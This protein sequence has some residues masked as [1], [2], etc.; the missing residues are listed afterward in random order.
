MANPDTRVFIAFD[1]TASGGSFFA[2][3]DPVRGVL[4]S[5]YVLGGDV[6]VDVTNYVASVSIN[7]GKSRELDRFTAGNASV[8][9]HNDDRT[10][11]PFYSDSPFFSQI[12]PRKQVVIE[13]NGIRQ[14]TGYIDD[15]DLTYELGGKSFASISCIDGFMQLSATQL[16]EFTN[17]SQLSGSRIEAIINRPEVAWPAG[18]RDIDAG[19]ETLQADT[20]AENTNV[21]QYLQLIESTEPGALFMSKSGALT[22]RDRI[23]IPPLV[24]TLIF[25]DDGRAESVG[26]SDIE[27]VY[28]SEN[29]YNRVIVTREDGL[30]QAIDNPA[31]QA[32]YGVQTLSLDGLLLTTDADS[33]LLANYL[34]GRY[35]Q[36]E[37]RFSSLRVNLHDKNTSDQAELLAVEIQDVLKIIFTPN[38]IGDAI[39]RYG[40]VTGI[41]HSI[42]IDTHTVTFD[43]GSVQ[44]FPLILDDPIYGRL[45]G[46]LP[47]YDDIGTSYDDDLVRY[48]GSEEFGY[49]L[50]F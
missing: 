42:G 18:E 24:D 36:P 29:L 21:L 9:L 15:W 16:S 34:L 49:I 12:L 2:L 44:D 35:D 11:D 19:Q 1:L 22:F 43:F 30:P 26:Y 8:T 10:F 27:V 37:L 5:E 20:V 3:N 25:A 40:L 14:F 32:I 50:A 45:G 7:R 38:G 17:V 6:L 47:L 28:G 39:D 31:S 4:D 46:A 23:T 48:D 41:K 33:L 13:S